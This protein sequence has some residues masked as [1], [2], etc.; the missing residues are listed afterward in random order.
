MG[1][2]C[3]RCEEVSNEVNVGSHEKSDKRKLQ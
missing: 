1:S 3:D 2:K